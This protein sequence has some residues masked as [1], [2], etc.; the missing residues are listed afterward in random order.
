MFHATAMVRDYDAAVARLGELIGLRV[1]EYSAID[2]PAI[3][4]RGGMTWIGDGSLE[5]AEPIV[6]G[7]PPDR[8]V[9]R[10]GGGMQGVALWVDDFAA[11]VAHLA[12]ME[13]PMPVR[14]PAGFGFSSPRATCGLQFEWSEF[15]VH[16]DPRAG[17]PEPEHVR[18]PVLDVQRL[19]FVGAAVDEPI[20]V[21]ARLAELFGTAVTFARPEAPTGEA[22]AGVSVGD[23][24]LAL[25]ALAAAHDRPR[26]A[27]LGVRVPELDEARESLA[28]AGVT[29]SRES[30]GMVVLDPVTTGG[31]EIAVVDRLLPGD[32][33]S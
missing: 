21:A 23:C 6:A 33:R 20:E 12:S 19:A 17:A 32:P 15:T 11:T 29:V 2:D 5:L 3:G 18:R 22:A 7:A 28:G 13:V 26:V 31:V 8:F 24:T 10:T 27:L 25:F 14:M 30:S 1:L 16:E 9:Q 4:R